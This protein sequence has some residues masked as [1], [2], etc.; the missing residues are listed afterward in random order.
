[1]SIIH[2]DID[3]LIIPL[4]DIYS[5]ANIYC[6]NKYYHRIIMKIPLLVQYRDVSEN[7]NIIYCKLL[8]ACRLGYLE[9]VQ[10]FINHCKFNTYIII[11]N[12][13]QTCCIYGQIT[14]AKYL[15]TLENLHK[16]DIH[17]SNNIFIRSCIAKN[18]YEMAK[19]LIRFGT[20][21]LSM[22]S[23]NLIYLN[24]NY[25]D[26]NMIKWFELYAPEILNS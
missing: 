23:N 14:I 24:T 12:L 5:L 15:L 13:F 22:F 21:R 10:Y 20:Y 6:T 3:Q 26:K 25:N 17:E 18:H 19:W 1:M 7:T 16:I 11:Q 4:L 9:C 2:P 8:A